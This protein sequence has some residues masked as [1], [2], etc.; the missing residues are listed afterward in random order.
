MFRFLH[1]SGDEVYV[2][3]TVDRITEDNRFIP[4]AVEVQ[5]R[6]QARRTFVCVNGTINNTE[7]SRIVLMRVVFQLDC[8]D[9]ILIINKTATVNISLDLYVN[10]NDML[11][12]TILIGP[13]SEFASWLNVIL[14]GVNLSST[15]VV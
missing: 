3:Y 14:T 6:G 4:I 1:E 15:L 13:Q 9:P 10:L 12:N 7:D 2:N 11:C 8:R 5:P